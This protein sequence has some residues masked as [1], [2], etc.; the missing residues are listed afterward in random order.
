MNII[1]QSIQDIDS[2]DKEGLNEFQTNK[3][4]FNRFNDA[5]VLAASYG[6]EEEAISYYN[7]FYLK[8]LYSNQSHFYH[9][10]RK[11][12]GVD[13][14]GNK[15]LANKLLI[16]KELHVIKK[17]IHMSQSILIKEQNSWGR[18][19]VLSLRFGT[20]IAEKM[21]KKGKTN[22]SSQDIL[23]ISYQLHATKTSYAFCNEFLEMMQCQETV[24][25][26]KEA[27]SFLKEFWENTKEEMKPTPDVFNRVK[28]III[29]MHGILVEKKSVSNLELRKMFVTLYMDTVEPLFV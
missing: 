29:Q 2:F 25:N 15:I 10:S 11:I 19:E 23:F 18:K 14:T 9:Y 26:T 13:T 8:S 12:N 4:R 27:I 1:I 28:T 16:M 22:M 3:E 21:E 7:F 24:M 6:L 17:E 5:M 20:E